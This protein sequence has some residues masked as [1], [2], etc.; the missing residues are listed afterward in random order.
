[1][2]NQQSESITIS[3]REFWRILA[4]LVLLLVFVDMVPSAVLPEEAGLCN[5]PQFHGQRRDNLS[6]DTGLMKRWP[7]VGPGLIWKAEGIGH[8]FSSVAIADGLIYTA[9]NMEGK[10]IITNGS[11]DYSD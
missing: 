7:E 9:G 3:Y 11:M 2:L 1:M 4:I 8:G 6:D 5:W 10:T